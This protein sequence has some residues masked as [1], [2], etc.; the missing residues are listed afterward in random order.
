VTTKTF[1]RINLTIE[2]SFGLVRSHRLNDSTIRMLEYELCEVYKISELDLDK[3]FR[4]SS[5]R[6][7]S[8]IFLTVA[9]KLRHLDPR[10]TRV[11]RWRSQL[12]PPR[13][14]VLLNSR[15]SSQWAM[16]VPQLC[17]S[18]TLRSNMKDE[19]GRQ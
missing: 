7:A 2:Y 19:L 18:S 3:E 11:K 8:S 5:I 15:D 12:L 14:P 1:V 13:L 6:A 10:E 16:M 4:N 9:R 17:D